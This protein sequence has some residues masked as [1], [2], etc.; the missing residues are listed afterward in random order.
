MN[1]EV[2]NLKPTN[3]AY[4]PRGSTGFPA[5]GTLDWLKMQARFGVP[6]WAI[7]QSCAYSNLLDAEDLLVLV[8]PGTTDL[9]ALSNRMRCRSCGSKACELRGATPVPEYCS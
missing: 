1:I 8:K 7:C 2:P 6:V 5:S 9:S 3:P 4:W